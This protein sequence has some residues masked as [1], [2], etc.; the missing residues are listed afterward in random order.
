VY[1]FQIRRQRNAREAR[2]AIGRAGTS[3]F[4]EIKTLPADASVPLRIKMK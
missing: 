1:G 3:A 4:K 2:L